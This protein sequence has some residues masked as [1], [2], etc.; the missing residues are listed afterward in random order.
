MAKPSILVCPAGAISANGYEIKVLHLLTEVGLS[1][2]ME[3]DTPLATMYDDAALIAKEM[4][5]LADAGKEVVLVAIP[6]VACRQ[7][8]APRPR[9]CLSRKGRW[10]ER[11]EAS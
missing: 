3:M 8:R 10:R 2:G 11:K 1:P 6:T 5:T 4:E 7:P 9:D